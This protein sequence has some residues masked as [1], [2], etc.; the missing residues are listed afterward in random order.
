MLSERKTSYQILNMCRA[1]LP[2]AALSLIGCMGM[3]TPP[4]TTSPSSA[5]ASETGGEFRVTWRAE[6]GSL[7]VA[8]NVFVL[9]GDAENI[10]MPRGPT[11]PSRVVYA[12][13]AVD[14]AFTVAF[15]AA[16]IRNDPVTRDQA[17][18]S[19]LV[20]GTDEFGRVSTTQSVPILFFPDFPNINLQ[21]TLDDVTVVP[22]VPP[23]ALYIL[24]RELPTP[25]GPFLSYLTS[26]RVTLNLIGFRNRQPTVVATETFALADSP[27]DVA[28]LSIIATLMPS[29]SG[30][31]G[32]SRGSY[33]NASIEAGIQNPN[34]GQTEWRP[35]L[36]VYGLSTI[37]AGS[38]GGNSTS[39]PPMRGSGP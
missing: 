38:A 16:E 15:P 33:V 31:G 34:T 6:P 12:Q 30:G 35:A 11:G 28:Q 22:G 29:V 5:Q 18:L 20:C 3:L 26:W 21:F 32:T 13:S 27:E 2:M 10:C 37:E 1:L 25:R 7:T 17:F 8:Y 14:G 23:S 9:P 4:E 24:S 36:S 39:A 19:A